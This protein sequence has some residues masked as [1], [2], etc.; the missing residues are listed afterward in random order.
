[1]RAAALA[2]LAAA[3]RAAPASA[4]ARWSS[5]LPPREALDFDVVVVGAGPAGLAAALQLKKVSEGARG[6]GRT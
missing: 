2:A 1:M 5:S 4:S 3:R 6:F